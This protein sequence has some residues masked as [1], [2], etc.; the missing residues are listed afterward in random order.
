MDVDGHRGEIAWARAALA[1]AALLGDETAGEVHAAATAPLSFRHRLRKDPISD[2]LPERRM[3]VRHGRLF[4]CRIGLG[5]EHAVR[6]EVC[7]IVIP[8]AE[9]ALVG[10]QHG[11]HFN[12]GADEPRRAR[13]VGQAHIAAHPSGPAAGHVRHAAGRALS[14]GKVAEL[15]S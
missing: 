4:R 11:S 7:R 15:Q 12:V 10:L 8:Y 2:V 14:V 5:P 6:L 3:P 13:L 1:L 9:A